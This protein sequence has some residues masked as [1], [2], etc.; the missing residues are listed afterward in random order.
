MPNNVLGYNLTTFSGRKTHAI[1]LRLRHPK[2][3][4]LLDYESIAGTMC[5]E[6][7]HC[8]VGPHNAEFYKVME[9]IEEQYSVF[10]TRGVVVDK[11]GFP[12]GSGEAHVLG[13][14]KVGK[15]EARRKGLK[16][17]EVRRGLTSGQYVLGG[18]RKKCDP[19]EAARIA[20]ERRLRDSKFCLPS[21]E[22]IE[23]LGDSDDE[24]TGN[25]T[26][27]QSSWAVKSNEVIDLTEDE[28]KPD[29]T[30]SS[31]WNASNTI[32]WVCACCT[33]I[34]QP[35]SLACQVCETPPQ[36]PAVASASLPVSGQN[37]ESY[38]DTKT[39]FGG[40]SKNADAWACPQ[41]T[42][43]NPLLSLVCGACCLERRAHM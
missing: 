31:S 7:A 8:V 1:H 5:H 4:E 19:R 12:V 22:V 24:D 29:T 20:A 39:K 15:D 10:L 34:N 43:D 27:K 40:L 3:H 9:E 38:R 30:I 26:K 32:Q 2:T 37:D 18:E 41:C 6:L 36:I 14:G 11:D 13:G 16:A 28:V 17:A 35:A 42:F 21:D 33:L 23:I 25:A